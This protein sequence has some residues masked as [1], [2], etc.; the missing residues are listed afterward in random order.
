MLAPV[1][2]Y[3]TLYTSVLYHQPA[4]QSTN[5]LLLSTAPTDIFQFTPSLNSFAK[6]RRSPRYARVT[7]SA[8]YIYIYIYICVCFRYMYRLCM[9]CTYKS[10]FV[11]RS[12]EGK[13]FEFTYLLRRMLLIPFPILWY[14]VALVQHL[15]SNR[16]EYRRM[17]GGEW[18]TMCQCVYATLYFL[19]VCGA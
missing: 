5:L 3:T 7:P 6:S 1:R 9:E 14:S 8:I 17:L 10:A 2:L 4:L 18:C 15:R 19:E 16:L 13:R 12:L 11:A